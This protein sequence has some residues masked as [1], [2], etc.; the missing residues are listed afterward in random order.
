MQI[1]VSHSVLESQR[2]KNQSFNC[3]ISTSNKQSRQSVV[4]CQRIKSYW[5]SRAAS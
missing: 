3:S 2:V 5:T 1:H 4:E